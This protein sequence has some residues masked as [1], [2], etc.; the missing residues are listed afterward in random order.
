MSSSKRGIKKGTVNNPQGAN[1]YAS[2]K[3]QGQKNSGLYLRISETDKE[4][5]KEAAEKQGMTLSNWLLSMAIEAA[6]E[7]RASVPLQQLQAS[8]PNSD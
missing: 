6:S 1:Q 8:F 7:V 2:G 3:G 4:K 5:L